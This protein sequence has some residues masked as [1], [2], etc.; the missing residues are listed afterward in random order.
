MTRLE[1]VLHQIRLKRYEQ[2]FYNTQIVS[3]K[4]CVRSVVS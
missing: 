4:T 2:T 3:Q 1:M